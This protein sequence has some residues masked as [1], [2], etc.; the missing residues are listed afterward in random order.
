LKESGVET[1]PFAVS[2]HHGVQVIFIAA[3]GACATRFQRL[4]YLNGPNRW[5]QQGAL[6]AL[7]ESQ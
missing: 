3:S 7:L 5:Q 6:P 4:P 2:N 1:E